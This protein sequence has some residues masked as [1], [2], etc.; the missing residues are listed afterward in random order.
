MDGV[1][2]EVPSS[3]E[4]TLT[5]VLCIPWLNS[6]VLGDKGCKSHFVQSCC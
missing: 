6:K 1:C 4:D 5:K 3:L 2:E